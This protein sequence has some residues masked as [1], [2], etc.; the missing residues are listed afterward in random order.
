MASILGLF[1]LTA[2][3]RNHVLLA[4]DIVLTYGVLGGYVILMAEDLSA[5]LRYASQRGDASVEIY[6]ILM[7]HTFVSGISK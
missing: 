7:F 6:G 5:K 2:V 4:G 1:L 3:T